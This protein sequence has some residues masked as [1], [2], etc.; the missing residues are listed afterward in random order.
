MHTNAV[1]F[2]IFIFILFG[3]AGVKS[4]NTVSQTFSVKDTSLNGILYY[5]NNKTDYLIQNTFEVQYDFFMVHYYNNARIADSHYWLQLNNEGS[6]VKD[7]IFH[8]DDIFNYKRQTN[9]YLPYIYTPQNVKYFQNRK[10]YTSV[11][12]RRQSVL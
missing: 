2:L 10:A 7:M 8:I 1:K 4:Q 12:Y 5:N 3:I 9:T 6:A 11:S